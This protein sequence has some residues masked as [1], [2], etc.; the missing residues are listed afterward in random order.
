[1]TRTAADLGLFHH[2]KILVVE[3][4]VFIALDIA[5]ELECLGAKVVGPSAT[6]QEGLQLLEKNAVDG[7]I[8]DVNLLDGDALPLLQRLANEQVA[9]VIH[10]GGALPWVYHERFPHLPVCTKPTT[11]MALAEALSGE[12]L[13][14]AGEAER[15][16]QPNDRRLARAIVTSPGITP[17]F[18]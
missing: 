15:I 6:A 2:K 14:R 5:T 7:A 8:A 17:G 3:D 1:M 10:T 18:S 11:P 12:I 16:P 9:V 13:A 4:E